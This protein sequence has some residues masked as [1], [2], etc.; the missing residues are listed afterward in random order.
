[1]SAV[2]TLTCTVATLACLAGSA[3]AQLDDEPARTVVGPMAG[4]SFATLRGSGVVADA[5]VRSG[6][7]VGGFATFTISPY[8]AFEPQVVYVQKGATF[9]TESSNPDVNSGFALT[10]LEI[11]LLF[12]ARYPLGEGKWP[13]IFSVI[14][15]P[16]IG[17]NTGCNWESTGGNTK[18]GTRNLAPNIFDPEPTGVDYSAVFGVG[19]DVWHIAFQARYDYSFTRTFSNYNPD[20]GDPVDIKNQAWEITLGYKIAIE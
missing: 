6:I 14:A 9:S 20:N 15:G 8:F 13:T 1:V 12:K 10:Y 5:N 2:R 17:L 3:T 18:C 19:L 16:A 7:I 11:P 4:M